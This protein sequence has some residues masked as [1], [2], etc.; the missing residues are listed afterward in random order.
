MV[1]PHVI[2]H[3]DPNG[4]AALRA[5]VA[6]RKGPLA[7]T[8]PVWRKPDPL[9]AGTPHMR[10][11]VPMP[12]ISPSDSSSIS[13]P[14]NDIPKLTRSGRT[15]S[16]SLYRDLPGRS[17]RSPN[18]RVLTLPTPRN[19]TERYTALAGTRWKRPKT[20][21]PRIANAFAWISE[22]EWVYVVVF[23]LRLIRH[24]SS[25]EEAGWD[26]WW[27]QIVYFADVSIPI[28]LSSYADSLAALGLYYIRRVKW[29][30][31]FRDR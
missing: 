24:L 7:N 6:D 31:L 26:G 3:P 21:K 19:Q 10:D 15:S 8:P 5:L 22:G 1:E 17:A 25:P 30:L 18:S 28:A 20:L 23:Y 29:R 4:I 9:P 14:P 2:P 27:L 16:D 12:P 13:D 11:S